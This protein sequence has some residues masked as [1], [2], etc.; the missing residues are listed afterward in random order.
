MSD[1]I[2]TLEEASALYRECR[3]L[4][5]AGRHDEAVTACES[6][7]DRL[8]DATEAAHLGLR[9]GVTILRAVALGHGGRIEEEIAVY[10]GSLD[11]FTESTDPYVQSCLDTA[12]FNLG[13]RLN[14]IEHEEEAERT[15]SALLDRHPLASGQPPSPLAIK[16]GLRR[17][18]ILV[19]LKRIP[20]AFACWADLMRRYGDAEEPECA[21]AVAEALLGRSRLHLDAGRTDAARSDVSLARR[22]LG[23]RTPREL[24]A[25]FSGCYCRLAVDS[26][27]TGNPREALRE[28]ARAIEHI[29]EAEA[30]DREE[31]LTT[32]LVYQGTIF[33]RAGRPKS[34]LECFDEVIQRFAESPA[35]ASRATAA[36]AMRNRGIALA[37][38]G[39]LIDALA[40]FDATI[41][42]YGAETDEEMTEIVTGA[43]LDKA[44]VLEKL[45]RMEECLVAC[46]EVVR[47]AE[48]NDAEELRESARDARAIRDRVQGRSPA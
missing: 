20:E 18:Q 41:S 47:R 19:R 23:G 32:L 10:R 2:P 31:L 5:A 7:L 13:V 11:A 22:I 4:D 12:L 45:G 29:R 35:A 1:R 40:A 30:S 48:E 28:N 3:A 25:I 36:Q 33:L 44:G 26:L 21:P 9:A 43:C 46:A 37:E 8:R 17:G 15:L 6:L 38:D 16:A 34:A 39:A 14:Q 27:K 42:R 24:H